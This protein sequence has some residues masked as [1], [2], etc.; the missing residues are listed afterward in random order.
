MRSGNLNARQT[1]LELW[2]NTYGK[3]LFLPDG[4]ERIAMQIPQEAGLTADRFI[5]EN[6]VFPLLK[7]FL[8]QEKCNALSVAMRFGDS[9]IYNILG[10]PRTFTLRHRKLRYCPKCAARETEVFGEP[11]WHRIHQ[12]PGVYICPTHKTTTLES[13]ISVEEVQRGY[14]PVPVTADC[15]APVYASNVADKLPDYARDA[16][17]LLQHGCGLDCYERTYELYDKWLRVR[18]C[19]DRNGKTNGKMLAQNAVAYYGREFLMLFDCYNS[20]ACTWTRRLIRRNTFR[21]PMHHLLL[22]RPLAGSAEAFFA[23]TSDEICRCQPYGAPP[24]PCRN[25]VCGHYLQDVIGTIEIKNVKGTYKAEF[26]CPYCGFTYRRK[27][28]LPKE[29]Q[30]SGQIDV[31]DYGRLW[32]GTLK[33]MLAAKTSINKIAKALQCDTRTVVRFGIELGFFP[34]EQ[35]PKFRPYSAHPKVAETVDERRDQYRQRW[36]TA[37]AANPETTRNELRLVDSAAYHWLHKRDAEWLEQNSPPSKYGL[38]KWAGCD[39]EYVQKIKF[40]VEKIRGLPGRPKW[41]NVAS[42]GKNADIPQLYK[43][44]A[45]GRLPKTN[46]FVTANTESLE[47]WQKRKIQWAVRYMRECGESLTVYKVRYVAAVQDKERKLDGFIAQCIEN[48]AFV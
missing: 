42:I 46:A 23:G 2:G 44:L 14:Y 20:G 9:N 39:E 12:F 22:M 35:Q 29:K 31:A 43:V 40:A 10:F 4:I 16:A 32:H 48:N 26:V 30:Y 37:I 28:P 11:Y 47:Q 15:S 5:S 45:S 8:T 6:T 36:L 25:V 1:N 41:I 34:S 38:P 27:M 33:N 19:R 13:D 21:H 7:P 18:D 17:W 3:R 24:Y